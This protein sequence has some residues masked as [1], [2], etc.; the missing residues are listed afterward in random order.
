VPVLKLGRERPLSGA[1]RLQLPARSLSSA[2]VGLRRPPVRDDPH[3]RPQRPPPTELS[4]TKPLHFEQSD[5]FWIADAGASG[6]Y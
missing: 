5:L 1:R 3:A 2:A 6:R 4:E